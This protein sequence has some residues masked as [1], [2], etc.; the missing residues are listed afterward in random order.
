M[1]KVT[2]T[3]TTPHVVTEWIAEDG[4]VFPNKYDCQNYEERIALDALEKS[5][6]VEIWKYN[7]SRYPNFSGED[8]NSDNDFLWYKPLNQNGIELLRNA[9][10]R[11]AERI[12]DE[13]VGKW[14]CIEDCDCDS[15]VSTLDDGINYVKHVLSLFGYDVSV[16]PR[17][18]AE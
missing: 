4:T 8:I 5:S 1:K 11:A 18:E 14:I 6:D 9:H 3:I 7:S 10:P 16:D 15:W 12:D 13:Y 17:E 2:K